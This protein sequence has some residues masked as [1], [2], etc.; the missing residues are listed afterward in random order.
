[1]SEQGHQ[2]KSAGD[3]RRG[4]ETSYL[5]NSLRCDSSLTQA[6]I[7]QDLDAGRFATTIVVGYVAFDCA[8]TILS[9][10]L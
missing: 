9:R 1:M 3:G 2:R 7:K 5:R 6:A 8:A 10:I 4:H